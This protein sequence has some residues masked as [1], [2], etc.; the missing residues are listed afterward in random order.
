MDV[1]LQRCDAQ[2]DFQRCNGTLLISLRSGDVQTGKSL[3]LLQ[4]LLGNLFGGVVFG[5]QTKA[6]YLIIGRILDFM[7]SFL[8]NDSS[9]TV[10][11][12]HRNV[13]FIPFQPHHFKA[14]KS[15]S[16]VNI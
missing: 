3:N 11:K 2:Q 6:P 12:F 8:S 16:M 5:H 14:R 15:T 13:Q 7:V 10:E 9:M 4:L 1:D